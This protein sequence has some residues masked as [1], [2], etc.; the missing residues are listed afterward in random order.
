MISIENSNC[1][2]IKNSVDEHQIKAAKT[3]NEISPM[4]Q[5]ELNGVVDRND[6][7]KT[8]G[9]SSELIN[10]FNGIFTKQ[11]GSLNQRNNSNNLA[12][13]SSKI[14]YTTVNNFHSP[15]VFTSN[16]ITVNTPAK[17]VLGSKFNN[18]AKNLTKPLN[19]SPNYWQKQKSTNLSATTS[20][21]TAQM[22]VETPATVL[23]KV[24]N[25]TAN[26]GHSSTNGNSYIGNGEVLP[27][28]SLPTPITKLQPTSA[29]YDRYPKPGSY[30][31]LQVYPMNGLNSVINNA[32]A[33]ENLSPKAHQHCIYMDRTPEEEISKVE[34]D[35]LEEIL[36]MCADFERQNQNV[37]SS[38][39][40]Q[41]RIKT[42]GSLPREKKSP[43][44]PDH[45]RVGN[46]DV[47]F[48][49][50]QTNQSPLQPLSPQFEMTRNNNGYE[51]F[52]ISLGHTTELTPTSPSSRYYENSAAATKSP[53]TSPYIN[54]GYENITNVRKSPVGYVP[55]SPRTRIKTFISPKK[56]PPTTPIQR[57]TDYEL[58]VQSFEEK[59]RFEAQQLREQRG[60]NNGI[61]QLNGMPTPSAQP[62]KSK[63]VEQNQRQLQ[64]Q[65]QQHQHRQ[66]SSQSEQIATALAQSINS[67]ASRPSDAQKNIYGSLQTKNKNINNLTV[68]IK[69]SLDEKQI[70]QLKRQ[71]VEVLK[72]TREL[73][74]QISELQRQEE[75]VLREVCKALSYFLYII[76]CEREQIFS[77][78]FSFQFVS[79]SWIWKRL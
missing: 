66:H 27:M 79:I 69:K 9:V 63:T 12:Q 20:T 19:E 16:S 13:N 47:F 37:Q 62:F 61:N 39:I 71:Q 18:F 6:G 75:E 29:C 15:K 26:N 11:S 73:K 22:P 5:L 36:K 42:N 21:K 8:N 44:S 10:N 30:G 14:E 43:I 49:S 57:K 59:L 40:V 32:N 1:L 46:A 68:N 41:N 3:T 72:N 24:N 2:H 7:S 53:N 52:K 64:T 67:N 50:R 55:Q 74:T 48:P 54:N 23:T 45:M 51:N 70:E 25:S 77:V 35:R 33:K 58:L 17:D 34:Q 78:Y 65:Q 56:E 4:Q 38:P 28:Q 60:I 76:V 31:S